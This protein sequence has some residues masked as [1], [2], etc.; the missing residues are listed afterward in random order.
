MYVR[1]YILYLHTYVYTA[2][3]QP[4]SY[5]TYGYIRTVHAFDEIFL[6]N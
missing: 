4:P 5:A 2:F 6:V 3:K 1:T